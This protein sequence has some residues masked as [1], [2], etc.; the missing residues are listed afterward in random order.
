MAKTSGIVQKATITSIDR[1]KQQPRQ[2]YRV[3]TMNESH[4]QQ[5]DY[6]SGQRFGNDSLQRMSTPVVVGNKDIS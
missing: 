1:K 5:Q 2:S 4:R 3:G 6:T